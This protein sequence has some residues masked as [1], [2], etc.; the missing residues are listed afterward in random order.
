MTINILSFTLNY[1]E[2]KKSLQISKEL[3]EAVNGRTGNG[4]KNKDKWTNNN[5]QNI[6]QKTNKT[7]SKK[8]G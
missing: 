2:K 1:R 4:Q 7:N 3:P 6:T 5:P 8:Q